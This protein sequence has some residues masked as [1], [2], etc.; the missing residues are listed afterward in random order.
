[1]ANE[2]HDELAAAQ[3]LQQVMAG[4]AS[5]AHDLTGMTAFNSAMSRDEILEKFQQMAV[6]A[7]EGRAG[8][9]E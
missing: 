1:M 7:R 6:R 9:P 2:Q 4:R 5:T 3:E 8:T